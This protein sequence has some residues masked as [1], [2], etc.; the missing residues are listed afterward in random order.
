M[1][2]VVHLRPTKFSQSDL[3]TLY[4]LSDQMTKRRLWASTERLTVSEGPGADCWLVS[5]PG[6]EFATY[7]IERHADGFYHLIMPGQRGF[8]DKDRSLVSLIERTFGALA[9]A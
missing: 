5:L 2:N 7:S 3:E 4:R 6:S 1:S 8:L 9:P